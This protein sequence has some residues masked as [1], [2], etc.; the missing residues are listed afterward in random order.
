MVNNTA[1]DQ[2]AKTCSKPA[3]KGIACILQSFVL[4]SCAQLGEAIFPV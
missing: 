4:A 1:S 3:G 2:L